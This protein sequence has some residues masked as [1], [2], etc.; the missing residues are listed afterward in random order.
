MMEDSTSRLAHFTASVDSD[1][2]VATGVFSSATNYRSTSR[3]MDHVQFFVGGH[4]ARKRRKNSTGE[5]HE[6]SAKKIK[7]RT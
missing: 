7:H 3:I 6:L 1:R 2:T 5:S 4:E